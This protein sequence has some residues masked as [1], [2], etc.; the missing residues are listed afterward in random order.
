MTGLS[1]VRCFLS[2]ECDEELVEILRKIG[3]DCYQCGK[4]KFFRD[5]RVGLVKEEATFDSA[6]VIQFSD[7]PYPILH[8]ERADPEFLFASIT[9]TEFERY[10]MQVTSKKNDPVDGSGSVGS[11]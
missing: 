3:S 5:G 8:T 11:V 10:W 9:A 1:Y 2:H 7:Q 4:L 6:K